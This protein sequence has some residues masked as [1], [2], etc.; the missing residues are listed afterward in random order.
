MRLALP[1]G[2]IL[3][4][5]PVAAV[6]AQQPAVQDHAPGSAL[7]RGRVTRPDG[8]P[9]AGADVW[10]ISAD[11]HATSDSAGAYRI[12]DLP[13]GMM[14]IEVRHIGFGTERD[15][16]NLSV[17]HENVRSYALVEQAPTLDTVRTVSRQ[18]AYRA[19]QL[20]AFEERRL[21]GQ[22][23]YFISDSTFRHNESSTLGNLLVGRLPGVN[24]Q[25]GTT[26]VSSTKQCRG[27][28]FIRSG[29]NGCKDTGISDCYVTI[30]LDGNMY[31]SAK[32]ADN[33]VQ[34]PNLARDFSV[35][36]LAGAEFYPD[37]ATAPAGMH[38]NDDGCGSLW[39]WSRA[40]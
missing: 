16:T 30:Y 7:L 2:F 33:A 40:P 34:P 19:P 35:T 18:Q 14:L 23:G 24:L 36:S 27:L 4:L 11:K 1:I 25:K 21:A 5:A 32:M 26:L 38:S 28:L 13:A 3:A 8:T 6:G 20:R 15:T 10:L 12:T 17:E 39:L 9:I 37:G 22:G 29:K 31:F